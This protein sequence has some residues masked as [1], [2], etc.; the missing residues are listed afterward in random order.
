MKTHRRIAALALKGLIACIPAFLSPAVNAGVTFTNVFVFSG[1]SPLGALTQCR[2]GNFYGVLTGG[3]YQNGGVFRV[4]PDG[5]GFT[6]LV[7]FGITNGASPNGTLVE[8]DDGSLY[9]TTQAGGLYGSPSTGGTVFKITTSGVLTTLVSFDGTNGA[10]PGAE[11]IRGMDG[12]FYGTT[13]QGGPHLARLY[14]AGSQFGCGTVF[15]L[16]PDGAFT[17]LYFFDSTNQMGFY[18]MGPLMQAKDGNFYGT[19]EL[20]GLTG[21]PEWYTYSKGTVFKMTP[22]G[23]TTFLASFDGTNGMIS[24]FG[25]VQ[26]A[27]GNL[28]GP[29][30][31]GTTRLDLLASG[32]GNVYCIKTDGSLTNMFSFN[33][34]NGVYPHSLWLGPDGNFYGMSRLGGLGAAQPSFAGYGNIFKLTPDGQLTVLVGFNGSNGG[35]PWGGLMQAGDGNLYGVTQGGSGGSATLFR[36]GLPLPATIKSATLTNNSVALTWSSVASQGY[37]VQYR[38]NAEQ[39]DWTNLGGPITAT[40]GTMITLD[41]IGPDSQ[42][43]YRVVVMP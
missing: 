36:L 8:G 24:R 12:N 37:Q 7:A 33:G 14:P 18:P 27:D 30:L 17:N 35:N 29:S 3:A 26:T 21:I 41:F 19:T 11:L 32:A 9:G 15:R 10:Q 23:V 16:A 43:F 28:Y 40:N 22:E 20:G 13:S 39:G 34:T 2:D 31:G 6:N 1:V 38:T 5:S 42:R 4:A 25:M